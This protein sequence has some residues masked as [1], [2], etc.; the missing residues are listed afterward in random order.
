MT[1]GLTRERLARPRDVLGE[2]GIY[3]HV[4]FCS[5]RCWYCDFN[6]YAGL[7]EVA[8]AYMDALV[9]DVARAASAPRDADIEQRPPVT[10][11]FIGGGTPSLVPAASIAR[12]LDALHSSW[13]VAPG[14][15]ITIECNPESVDADKLDAYRAAGIN[16][17][18]IGVQSLDARALSTLGRTH[19]A[20]AALDALRLAS[21]RFDQVS[22]DLIFGVPDEGDETWI[23]SV[24]GVLAT[25]VTHMSCYGLTYE[26]G[27]PLE[28]W[29][30]LGKITPV[31]EDDV[32]RR[33]EVADAML[34]ACG[35]QRYEISN[36]GSPSV[37]N[38]LYWA[39]GEYLGLGAGAHSHLATSAGASRSWT[40][41]GPERYIRAVAGGSSTVAGREEI[42]ERTRA[43]EV[44]V[45]GLRRTS[46]VDFDSFEA[47][48]GR[49][50]EDV[51]GAE[52]EQGIR[53][54]L[55]TVAEGSVRLTRPLLGNAAAVLFA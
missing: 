26:E 52:L 35:L 25:G 2:F 53:R 23:A 18:S 47:L 20:D 49:P 37:H 43:A 46:G 10:S 33:W 3:I 14:A 44:M 8:P 22:G 38:G 51:Y 48:T 30:K 36:W 19:S 54:D 42:D 4:P 34:A 12:V 31:D 1:V 41:K 24:R 50:I 9:T 32:A 17:I 16:R 27:T 39:C 55:L 21:V 5:N 45:L 40:L 28:S 7:D 11:V 29:R 15:E 13:D 6:A